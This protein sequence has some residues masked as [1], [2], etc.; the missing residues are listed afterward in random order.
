MREKLSKLF[1]FINNNFEKGVLIL[2]ALFP[3][4]I[5]A[6][7]CSHKIN[8]APVREDAVGYYAYLPATFIYQDLKFNFLIQEDA[9]Y[10]GGVNSFER[11]YNSDEAKILGFNKL[12]NGNFIDK[13]PIGVAIMLAP[14]YMVG[15]LLTLIVGGQTTG[16]SFFYQYCSVW[17]GM[18]YFL[19][20]L[21]LLRRILKSHYSNLVT[22]FTL[23]I[24][25]LGTNLLN[26]ALYENIFSHVYSF[27]LITL[28]IYLTPKWLQEINHKNSCMIG[29][30]CGLII[31]ARFTNM[32]TLL[33]PLLYGVNSFSGF[34]DQLKRL[35][36]SKI[37]LLFAACCMILALIPQIFYW[38]AVSGNWFV[39]GYQDEGF[40][41]LAPKIW[42]V[43]FGTSKGLF[44]WTPILLLSIPGYFLFKKK[45]KN[46][47]LSFILIL[48]IQTYLVA[49]WWNWEYGWSF[50]HRGFTDFL[51]L[52]AIGIASFLSAIKDKRWKFVVGILSALLI[53]L[54]LFQMIQYWARILPP[55]R[56]TLSDYKMIF[57]RLDKK[58][59]R[60]WKNYFEE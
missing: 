17:G 39:F 29:L 44:F 60:F 34:K 6:A 11:E 43:L 55:A 13:Y 45:V 27:F 35:W 51:S 21:I 7:Y 22:H 59:V 1:T 8:K 12:E 41:F 38:K 58:Y 50:G 36:R 57:L 10:S 9:P 26:Y 19:L 48:L 18:T 24:I 33:I 4:L 25:V 40:N 15:H 47:Q 3:A 2:I 30:A 54:S 14:F 53:S 49:S 28:L 37:P 23:L 20:G 32:I 46:F 31:A 52:F 56:T 5:I 16:W 42:Q